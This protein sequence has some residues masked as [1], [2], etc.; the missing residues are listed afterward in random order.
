MFFDYG[1]TETEYLKR[2]D[3]R[4]GV[5]I[6]YIG[7]VYRPVEPDV[8]PAVLHHVVG[9]QISQKA[10]ESVWSKVNALLGNITP[11]NVMNASCEALR[12]C[13]MSLK[14]AEYITDFASKVQSGEFDIG[15]LERMPDDEAIKYMSSLKGVGVW[16]AEMMLL[17]SLR[18]PD[19]LSFGDFGI[20]HGMRMI[21]RH[22]EITKD[23]FERYR[24]RYSPYGSVASLYLWEAAA[25]RV[26][27]LTDPAEPRSRKIKK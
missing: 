26:P 6:D 15:S 20:R 11:E 5:V 16:T 13:G 7:H 1:T 4:L 23:L 10:M 3:K 25:G 24:K 27:G 14:K 18:R 8:F 21:Y 9:Q 22:K 2:K 17:F 19:V 12:G